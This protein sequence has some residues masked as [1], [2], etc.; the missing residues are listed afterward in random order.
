MCFLFQSIMVLSTMAYSE[1]EYR[2]GKHAPTYKF[3]KWSVGVGWLLACTSVIMIPIFLII[4]LA[5][6]NGSLREV[7]TISIL[8]YDVRPRM[9]Y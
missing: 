6:E 7:N 1:L 9:L 2:R 3:P 5:R 8:L 4:Q